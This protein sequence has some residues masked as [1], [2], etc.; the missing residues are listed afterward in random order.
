MAPPATGGRP[1]V[2]RRSWRRR[3]CGVGRPRRHRR[4][5]CPR[6]APRWAAPEPRAGSGFAAGARGWRTPRSRRPSGPTSDRRSPESAS[7]PSGTPRPSTSSRCPACCVFC[8]IVYSTWRPVRS[9]GSFADEPVRAAPQRR[10]RDLGERPLRQVGPLQRLRR[11]VPRLRQEQL[12]RA[13]CA[14]SSSGT[15]GQRRARGQ[16]GRR[17]VGAGEVE[18]LVG[19]RARRCTA[20]PSGI[21]LRGPGRSRPRPAGC[22]RR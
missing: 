3:G 1:R 11:V 15:S 18:P 22:P 10:V 4:R 12:E 13:R 7:S 6:A 20:C 21:D 16:A 19:G 9:A 8:Q 5:R 14:G 2:L 17:P